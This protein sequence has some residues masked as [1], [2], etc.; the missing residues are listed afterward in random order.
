LSLVDRD[1]HLARAL[2]VESN[3]LLRSV[4]S[5]QLRDA[6]IGQVTAVGKVREARMQ[7]EQQRF[8]IVVCNREFDDSTESGQDL[9]DEL[10]RERLLPHSTVFIMVTQQAL[11][12]QVVE[13]AESALDGLL[14][15]PYS[16][17]ALCQRIQEAR[18][19]KREL[20]DVLK[21]L[22]NGQTEAAFAFALKRFHD[23]APYAIWCGRLAAELLLDMNRPA[24][25]RRLFEALH[26]RK[27]A[28][29]AL[30]GMG[31][32]LAASGDNAAARRALTEVLQLDPSCADAH[33][34]Q[35]QLLVELGD[36]EGA[37]REYR[38][39]AEMTPG[40]LLRTQ[41]AGVLAFY[42]GHRAAARHWLEQSLRLGVQSK[43]FDA[44]SLL[45]LALLRSDDGDEVGVAA[46]RDQLRRYGARH[47]ESRRLGLMEQAAGWLLLRN[48]DPAEAC[49]QWL[50]MADRTT[51]DDFDLESANLLLSLWSR[52]PEAVQRE[53]QALAVIERIA[54]RFCV[55][56]STAEV[57]TA[58][59]Q[60]TELAVG[61]I[62]R[63]QADIS[64]LAEQ[65]MS[66]SLR[67]DP[68][69]AIQGLLQEGERLSNA[70]LLEMA[71]AIA[72][73]HAGNLP[74]S[75]SW[76]D[77]AASSLALRCRVTTHIA[78]IQRLGRSPGGLQLRSRAAA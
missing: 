14:L 37:L 74:E 54:L 27:P 8:D 50:A 12:H 35:G 34:V 38:A 44:L 55:A 72:R 41:H 56:K 5:G 53:D 20:F 47:P 62:R 65:A 22:D 26:A 16:G 59:A 24:D 19:R 30:L 6:G 2:L 9:L 17:A 33:E 18:N 10:R 45:L 67:G 21:A 70:K 61:I 52:L 11:Y 7:L 60:R 71:A 23:Q 75:Q 28:P 29:W 46:A 57:L 25:A 42:Q 58:A 66:Q 3:H 68:A 43:L 76:I 73:R 51:D 39:A 13:A 64:A 1:I 69:S 36:F 49:K 4:S 77:R 48:Q 31:R 78:G 40:C 63:C 32:A 15:R